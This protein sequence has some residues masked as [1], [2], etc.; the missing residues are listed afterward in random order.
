MQLPVPSDL[1]RASH[2]TT[3]RATCEAGD[4]AASD[5]TKPVTK[6][7]PARSI[8]RNRE[9]LVHAPAED[10]LEASRRRLSADEAGL[11]QAV[12]ERILPEAS[13]VSAAAYVERKLAENS[14]RPDGTRMLALYRDGIARIQSR[15]HVEHGRSFQALDLWHQLAILAQLEDPGAA[16]RSLRTFILML[17]SDAAEAYFD[18]IE[19]KYPRRCAR[20]RR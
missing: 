4:F 13:H 7:P 9:P 12:F 20:D 17:V 1:S 15:C 6:G 18:A 19:R 2:A 16:P 10:A 5:G 3:T 11:I 14:L 8:T